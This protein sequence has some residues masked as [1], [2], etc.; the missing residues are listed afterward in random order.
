M[1]NT[2]NSK[3][4]ILVVL[5]NIE[6]DDSITLKR[7][8]SSNSKLNKCRLLIWNNGPNKLSLERR[9]ILDVGGIDEVNIVEDLT[10]VPLSKIYNFFIDHNESDFY[11][12]LDH[13]S[14]LSDE[15]I[16]YISGLNEDIFLGMPR[17]F[18]NNVP[19]SPCVN[20]VYADRRYYPAEKL[21]AIGSGLVISKRLV[22]FLK[23]AYNKVFDERYA[24]YGVDSS[25]FYRIRKLHYVDKCMVIPGFSHSLSRL[26]K[27]SPSVKQFRTYER[28]I[29][30]GLTLRYYPNTNTIKLFLI[31]MLKTILNKNSLSIAVAIKSIIS[32]KH[33]RCR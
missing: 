30:L 9:T 17:I 1:T 5:Y 11:V 33:P 13:D 28:S 10:N 6:I 8:F 19:C 4:S 2:C 29:D 21:T 23:K 15:Y 27:E 3:I 31:E 26:E 12:I 32:G 16:G 25:L 24:L 20:N 7:I 22:L 14:D 18:S